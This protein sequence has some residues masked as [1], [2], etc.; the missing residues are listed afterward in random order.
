MVAMAIVAVRYSDRPELWDRLEDLSAQV[1]PEYN[2]HGDVL[3]EYWARLYDDF[4]LFQFVLY[5]EERDE[6]LAEGHT[7]PV[8]WDGSPAGLG[9][10]IDHAI[11]AGFDLLRPGGRTS[12]PP[13]LVV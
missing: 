12:A 10:G 1:W 4:A 3:N 9:P 2:L 11:E 5:D 13:A 6:V 7:I 8:P